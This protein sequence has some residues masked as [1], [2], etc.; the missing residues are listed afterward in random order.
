MKNIMNINSNSSIFRFITAQTISLLGS[1]IVQYAIVW[2]ITLSTSSGM[3][4]T[5]S[6]ICGFAPQILISLFGGAM[7]DRYDRK[8]IIMLAD[9]MIALSTLIL[10][11]I[12]L[13]GHKSTYLLFAVL[14]IR[15]AGT[16]IQAPAVQS[17]IPQITQKDKLMRVNG[18]Y[19]TVTSITMFLSPAISGA[20]LSM[21]TLEATLLI[22]VATAAIGIALT[23]AVAIP[24]VH[25][26]SGVGKDGSPKPS[27]L[28]EIKAG[29][30]YLKGNDF[31]KTLLVFQIVILFLISPSAFL[32]P[33][34]VSREFGAEVWRLTASEMTYSIGTILGGLLIASWGGF[35]NKMTTTVTAG[36]LYGICMIG[37]GAAPMF[38]LY[39]MVNTII[40]V[41]SPCYSSPITVSIQERVDASMHG[42]VFSF[43]QL[44]G[45]CALPLGMAVFGPLSDYIPV[46]YLLIL[47]GS[48]VI[49]ATLF[50]LLKQRF[51]RA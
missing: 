41:T 11:G 28:A 46:Q 10:A 6:T 8:K 34:M 42:R 18:I 33:L 32:T 14:A 51:N 38:L 22:D 19:S 24:T 47:C 15:S 17:V 35:K 13:L 26:R 39:L 31:V 12:F 25:M 36:F 5:I 1:S 45:S 48:L 29:F 30:A 20:I 37:L 27:V 16:G 40:G 2:H 9:A 7:L 4:L 23:S 50:M 43:V 21:L 44:A 3:M 49:T